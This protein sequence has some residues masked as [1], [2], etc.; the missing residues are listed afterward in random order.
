MPICVRT[1]LN[2]QPVAYDSLSLSTTDARKLT[3]KTNFCNEKMPFNIHLWISL[4]L[5]PP[6]LASCPYSAGEKKRAALAG[7]LTCPTSPV[8]YFHSAICSLKVWWWQQECSIPWPSSTKA[9][10]SGNWKLIRF[11]LLCSSLLYFNS[12]CILLRLNHGTTVM[13]PIVKW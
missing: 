3:Q 11:F 10:P 9:V 12:C 13:C 7:C 8:C 2:S 4:T 6:L 5:L 1:E